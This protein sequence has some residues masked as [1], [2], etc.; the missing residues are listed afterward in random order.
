M[1]GQEKV[2]TAAAEAAG[3]TTLTD[4]VKVLGCS[5]NRRQ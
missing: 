5:W 2:K 1:A 4:G 3:V